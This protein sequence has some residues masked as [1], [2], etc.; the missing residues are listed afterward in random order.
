MFETSPCAEHR[1]GGAGFPEASLS[2]FGG[3]RLWPLVQIICVFLLLKIA[4]IYDIIM[5][6]IL[7]FTKGVNQ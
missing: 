6:M 7:L 5:L 4:R 2:S 1:R 3:S